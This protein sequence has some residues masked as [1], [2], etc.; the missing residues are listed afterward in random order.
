MYKNIGLYRSLFIFWNICTFYIS[1]IW[2]SSFF[3]PQL[4]KCGVF[5]QNRVVLLPM[6]S[7]MRGIGFHERRCINHSF[8]FF[9]LFLN[10]KKW[11]LGNFLLYLV[12]LKFILTKVSNTLYLFL[13]FHPHIFI[14]TCVSKHRL[15]F[16]ID[17]TTEIL[18]IYSGIRSMFCK[19]NAGNDFYDITFF[20]YVWDNLS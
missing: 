14:D 7:S 16:Y 17:F 8:F 2:I 20:V 13:E 11:T 1:G 12:I 15:F 4:D 5:N 18:Y 3:S 6:W 19:E 10:Q 9:T